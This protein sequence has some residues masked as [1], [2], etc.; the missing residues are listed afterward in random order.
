MRQIKSI[1]ITA[2]IVGMLALLTGCPTVS[3][4]L[5]NQGGG[6]LLSA[7][8]KVAGNNL[9]ALTPD[10]LQILSDTAAAAIDDPQIAGFEMSDAEASAL[11]E[12]LEV[13][14]ID[15]ID[16]LQAVVD[17]PGA[18]TIPDSLESLTDAGAFGGF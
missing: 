4:R 17:D 9:L 10:E 18:L 12:F 2:A 3:T 6:S 14:A 1:S 7:G 8:A 13:N 16:D 11:L 15:S 5:T